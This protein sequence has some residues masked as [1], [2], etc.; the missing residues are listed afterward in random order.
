MDRPHRLAFPSLRTVH[1]SSGLVLW[2]YAA[3][4]LGNHA[5][6][7]VSLGVAEGV[8]TAVHGL[9]RSVPG[10]IVL[11]GALAAHMALAL[12]AL[13][14]RRS[15]RMPALEA[16]RLALGLCLP[17]L[18]ALHVPATRLAQE[19]WGVEPSYARIVRSFWS[20]S[21]MAVQL[22]LLGAA[23]T[24][25]CMGLHLAL[26]RHAPWRRWQPLLLTGAVLLPVLAAL[27][28]L[29]MSREIQAGALPAPPVP[30]PEAA[31]VLRGITAA[32]REGWLAIVA[33]ALAGRALWRMRRARGRGGLVRLHYPDRSI[34]VPRGLS[35]LSEPAGGFHRVVRGADAAEPG[36]VGATSAA[37]VTAAAPAA[38]WGWAPS[39][40]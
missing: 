1:W 20:P 15:L 9:W 22:L 14:Q 18:L 16:V 4:H 2:A 36:A 25:G 37:P 13:W 21:G 5:L 35:V 32:L 29:S 12:H 27:G 11:Y 31:Q 33:L 39:S 10:S 26:R 24:H 3:L 40:S 17:L 6:G 7:L 30:S 34:E 19:A 28:I 38:G 23:W 8:R